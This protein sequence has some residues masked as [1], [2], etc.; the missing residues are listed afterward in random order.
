MAARDERELMAPLTDAHHTVWPYI[1]NGPNREPTYAACVRCT[2]VWKRV[3]GQWEGQIP[4]CPDY[5][6]P[7]FPDY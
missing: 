1:G 3:G 5:T 4:V 7:L 2:G 6:E